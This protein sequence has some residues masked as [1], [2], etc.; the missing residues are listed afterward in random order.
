M[1]VCVDY[2]YCR[3]RSI[4]AYAPTF[5]RFPLLFLSQLS[6]IERQR[7]FLRDFVD[8]NQKLCQ[9]AQ[10]VDLENDLLRRQLNESNTEKALLRRQLNDIT[11]KYE[12]LA[13]MLG[14]CVAGSAS[15]T[16][17]AEEAPTFEAVQAKLHALSFSA[18]E[19][20][21]SVPRQRVEDGALRSREHG[22]SVSSQPIT[23]DTSAVPSV[24]ASS[25][26]LQGADSPAARASALVAQ[27]GTA[28]T[29]SMTPPV[30]TPA[31]LGVD[32]PTESRGE[33]GT[34]NRAGGRGSSNV[35]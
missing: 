11:C 33:I 5:A 17:Q 31:A 19:A 6:M 21:E 13:S 24:L 22:A 2:Y 1:T 18:Q 12:H 30:S 20:V 26:V 27:E 23:R 34:T 15:T 3:I 35:R 10:T 9:H 8:T 25:V 4:N 32:T 28:P 29:T 14:Y 16:A 7:N